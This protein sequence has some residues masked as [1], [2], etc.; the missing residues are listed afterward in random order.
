M[1]ARYTHL[2]GNDIINATIEKEGGSI[3]EL[4]K[5]LIKPITMAK[6]IE[7]SDASL[8]INRLQSENEAL[9]TEMETMRKDMEKIQKFIKMGGMELISDKGQY[10]RH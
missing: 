10:L 3:Q 2:D 4:P 7:I 1:I 9:K 5:E 6:P 8:D